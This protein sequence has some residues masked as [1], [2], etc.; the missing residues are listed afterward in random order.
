M[1]RDEDQKASSAV[2]SGAELSFVP[3]MDSYVD[4][5]GSI[6]AVLSQEREHLNWECRGKKTSNLTKDARRGNTPPK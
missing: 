6:L 2:G 3:S 4:L 5:S 1:P